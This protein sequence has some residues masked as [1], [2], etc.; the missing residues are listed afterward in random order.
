MISNT[1]TK[2]EPSL[3]DFSTHQLL[4][5]LM[6]SS[7]FQI[8]NYLLDI[9]NIEDSN[10]FIF[11]RAVIQKREQFL[12]T[13]TYNDLNDGRLKLLFSLSLFYQRYPHTQLHDLIKDLFQ[14]VL[15]D[16]RFYRNK[17][18]WLESPYFEKKQ[19]LKGNTGI[20]LGIML[21]K[22]IWINEDVFDNIISIIDLDADI[23]AIPLKYR[24][25]ISGNKEIHDFEIEEA[26]AFTQ[27]TQNIPLLEVL[28]CAT[29]MH[30]LDRTNNTLF[31]KIKNLYEYFI[32]K[33]YCIANDLIDTYTTGQL[34]NTHNSLLIKNNN[35]K[36]DTLTNVNRIL[37]F[38]NYPIIVQYCSEKFINDL[39]S[40]EK[41]IIMP[42]IF[43]KELLKTY[44]FHGKKGLLKAIVAINEKR[45]KQNINSLYKAVEVSGNNYLEFSKL[46]KIT[47]HSLFKYSFQICMEG[48]E[49]K[50]S[51]IPWNNME[52]SK[53]FECN[54]FIGKIKE[55]KEKKIQ[56]LSIFK[57][58]RVGKVII[59]NEIDL[60]GLNQISFLCSF[61]KV[62]TV[63]QF[64]LQN[65]RVM[66]DERL[67]KLLLEFVRIGIIKHI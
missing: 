42:S 63:E 46:C 43:F 23:N 37:F 40:K 50:I 48:F 2:V 31:N 56:V 35:H 62:T 12:D 38:N 47:T 9:Q 52:L 21:L 57:P 55:L 49:V 13:E 60:L 1:I 18:S 29:F 59:W 17:L 32:E 3:T 10:Y 7:V 67:R 61:S 16:A 54:H 26:I 58:K 44:N 41:K 5:H 20:F 8:S 19:L 27:K 22:K 4:E 6:D 36:I 14:L 28:I 25:L 39:L 64:K 33:E 34:S 15:K 66:N 45:A 53:E 65:S 24:N 11:F 30:K 51:S